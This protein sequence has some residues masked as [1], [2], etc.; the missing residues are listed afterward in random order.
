ML[1]PRQVGR[2]QGPTEPL[3]LCLYCQMP[4]SLTFASQVTGPR[5]CM[6]AVANLK[7]DGVPL[8]VNRLGHN[9]FGCPG[10]F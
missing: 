9:D 2:R 7:T 4:R 6:M 8:P 5:I 10:V 3:L 1:L